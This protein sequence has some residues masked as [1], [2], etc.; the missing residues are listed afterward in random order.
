MSSSYR[1]TLDLWLKE[2]NVIADTVFDVG[3]SQVKV[4]DRVNTWEVENYVVFDL[5]DP[6]KGTKPDVEID[7]NLHNP[8]INGWL[9]M[10][11]VVFCLEVFEYVY[12]P[13][14]A[15]K[16][17]ADL[18]K[19]SGKLFV[20]FPSQY[21]LHQPVEDDALRYMPGGIAK[22]AASA[23]LKTATM[24]PR[25]FETN[26]YMQF[27]SAERL[28]AAKGEDHNFSGWICEFTK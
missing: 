15:M 28:R 22:L 8:E 16:T 2:H 7:L 1:N 23:G 24:T 19:P 17:L 18:M 3:G 11:D 26:A 12:N 21:P 9:K 25:R 4:K 20:T 5:P 27:V 6:H 13:V 14:K 10:A